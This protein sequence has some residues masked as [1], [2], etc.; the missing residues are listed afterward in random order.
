[1]ND[2][3]SLDVLLADLRARGFA[4]GTIEQERLRR[5][6]AAQ[7]RLH[8][9]G[10]VQ[11][12]LRELLRAALVR[13]AEQVG[14]FERAFTAWIEHAEASIGSDE[15]REPAEI[16]RPARIRPGSIETVLRESTDRPPPLPARRVLVTWVF[17]ALI[18]LGL[19]VWALSGG[20]ETPPQPQTGPTSTPATRPERAADGMPPSGITVVSQVSVPF[21][22]VT[23]RA[24]PS[25]PSR[26][27]WFLLAATS[28]LV[29][30]LTWITFRRRSA[31]LEP[32]APLDPK[33][34]LRGRTR[35]PQI[36]SATHTLID[37]RC[38]R[39]MVFGVERFVG[40]EPTHRIDL[41]RT[42]RQT[43]RRGGHLVL[44]REL[45]RHER[46]IWLWRD[47]AA[48]DRIAE[49]LV[50]ETAGTLRRAGLAVRTATC[51]GSPQ[52]IRWDDDRTTENPL[53]L[54]GQRDGV[55][56]ALFTDGRGIALALSHKERAPRMHE[57]LRSLRAWPRLALIP[58]G[59]DA[60]LAREVAGAARLP[61][62]EPED[63]AE[64]LRGGERRR[65]A[66]VSPALAVDAP[67]V[68]ALRDWAGALA[69]VEHPFDDES[70]W[71]LRDA[72]GLT[73][74]PHEVR[75]LRAAARAYGDRF[76][77]SSPQRA[78]LR[79]HLVRSEVD[80]QG[81]H[82]PVQPSSKLGRALAFWRVQFARE[83]GSRRMI[84]PA[85]LAATADLLDLEEA[86]LDLLDRPERAAPRLAA[87]A[88]RGLAD[89]IRGRL[90]HWAPMGMRTEAHESAAI[91]CLPWGHDPARPDI[92]VDQETWQT[93]SGL[94]LAESLLERR[95]PPLPLHL[96]FSL[97]A[98]IA[99]AILALFAGVTGW[100][101]D[102]TG[103]ALVEHGARP[104]D[105]RSSLEDVAGHVDVLAESPR[106][107]IVNRHYSEQLPG[108]SG[109][110]DVSWRESSLDNPERRDGFTVWRAGRNPRPGRPQ[111]PD[112][113]HRTV[114][115]LDFEVQGDGDPW[116]SFVH[117]ML[118]AGVV[119]IAYV[120]MAAHAEASV[121]ARRPDQQLVYIV[122]AEDPVGDM[123]NARE[124]IGR[125]VVVRAS[126]TTQLP[127]PGLDPV[128]V[129]SLW[130]AATIERE[131]ESSVRLAAAIGIDFVAIPA[132]RFA[133]GSPK[134]EE[135]RFDDEGYV[136]DVEIAAFDMARTEITRGDWR[137]V[138]PKS[139]WP[140]EWSSA[141]DDDA[142]PANFIDWGSALRFCNALSDREGLGRAY[143]DLK[144][145]DSV[146]T[147]VR[148]DRDADGYRLPTEA[149]WEY[150]ARGGTT[151]PYPWAGGESKLS[152]HAWWR[153]NADGPRPVGTKPA[154]GFGLH[155]MIGNVLEW[156]WDGW[157]VP[158]ADPRGRD[159]ST[160][161]SRVVRGGSFDYVYPRRL[162]SAYRYWCQPSV[163]DS[164]LGFRC[165]RAPRRQH[166][167]TP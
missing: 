66:A 83:R 78:E 127:L 64:F 43:A 102:R 27:H 113:P 99:I 47:A 26:S 75:A 82:H 119:D 17:G 42:V 156:C 141:R 100:R 128:A 142:L 80:D 111:F 37:A 79:D 1:M 5:V 23:V 159:E 154:N 144:D 165:V 30:G 48:D 112:W 132:G 106:A 117:R 55:I 150:A 151:T 72:L 36:E 134:E 63:L 41:P 153:K 25:A 24:A 9:G 95:H 137:R 68:G 71:A 32:V 110:F 28:A 40:E 97:G 130:Q 145:E 39:E 89:T 19:A 123:L 125:F 85:Q 133:L 120:G 143:P 76:R 161:G 2:P 54:E 101:S 152:E 109:V 15:P 138:M 164:G 60:A 38:A 52:A 114:L 62:V 81:R 29:A 124:S 22:E 77:F 131:S 103:W 65:V 140:T 90:R 118:D 149:E 98:G 92:G 61:V 70:A 6:F 115:W 69:L 163:Q 3:L 53:F 116:Q 88:E 108:T 56:V 59:A 46:T 148:W 45:P 10:E 20:G 74:S 16:E 166:G 50:R 31:A 146:S 44:C 96:R 135:G 91:A 21:P 86:M 157:N 129:N 34:T 105:V 67:L 155:D 136:R 35:A 18:L 33:A 160:D 122:Q 147:P 162:R 84:A 104:A 107:S 7:P 167:S 126:D 4:I 93:L 49:R 11:D 87:L 139:S 58:G 158:G 121:A 8:E 94:G 73:C 51:E 13:H 57:L 12:R 14:D